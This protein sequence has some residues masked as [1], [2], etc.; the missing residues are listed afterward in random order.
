MKLK[1]I[2]LSIL[3]LAISSI[4]TA[5]N[6]PEDIPT[7]FKTGD[8]QRLEK[9]MDEKI[10]L[11]IPDLKQQMPRQKAKEA[12]SAFFLKNKPHDFKTIHQSEQ[13]NSGYMIGKLVTGN[14]E[15][16]VH[17]LMKIIEKKYIIHQ[18]RI[19]NF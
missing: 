4:I 8:I 2:T 16:R 14:G 12:L 7:A 13:N 1:I 3:F 17:V 11:I 18:L 6:I 5:Q 10:Y 15:F 19:E 9:Y